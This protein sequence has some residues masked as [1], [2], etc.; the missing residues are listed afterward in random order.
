VQ[1]YMHLATTLQSA[2]HGT[3]ETSATD[4]ISIRHL[5]WTLP[6]N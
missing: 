1:N 5:Q 2:G 3:V 4:W 6:Q